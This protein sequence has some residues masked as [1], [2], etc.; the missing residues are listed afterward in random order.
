MDLDV[1][2]AD[3]A[4][5]TRV[6]APESVELLLAEGLRND[7]EFALWPSGRPDVCVTAMMLTMANEADV[8]M[9]GTPHHLVTQQMPDGGWNCRKDATHASF[10]TTLST[11]RRWHRWRVMIPRLAAPGIG[12]GSSCL[13]ITCTGPPHGEGGSRYIHA[14]LVPLLLVLRRTPRVGLL[15]WLHLRPTAG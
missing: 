6:P 1:L 11:W 10:H 4:P 5:A 9:P 14:F 15:A 7:G 12:A 2:L 13:P 3:A 8:N